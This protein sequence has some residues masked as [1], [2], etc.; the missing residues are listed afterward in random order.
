MWK[1]KNYVM[2]GIGSLKKLLSMDL[3]PRLCILL[4]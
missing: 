4:K 3:C 1:F 2:M